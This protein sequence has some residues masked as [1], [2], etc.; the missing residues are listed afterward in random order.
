M[1]QTQ[2]TPRERKIFRLALKYARTE[3][4]RPRPDF[5][6]NAM[7]DQVIRTLDN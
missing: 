3:Q 2:I 1:E 4:Q 7:V 6:K 5:R